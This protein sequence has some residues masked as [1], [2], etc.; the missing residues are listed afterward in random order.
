MKHQES[1]LKIS[2]LLNAIERLHNSGQYVSHP[3]IDLFGDGSGNVVDFRGN[4]L[5]AF[6]SCEEF[7]SRASALKVDWEDEG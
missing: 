5:W 1:S 3:Y 6:K 7:V 2:D 4:K